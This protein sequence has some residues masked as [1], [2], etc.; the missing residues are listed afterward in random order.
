[1]YLNS[2]Q[3]NHI[4][5]RRVFSSIN[6]INWSKI[7][8]NSNLNRKRIKGSSRIHCDLKY[9]VSFTGSFSLICECV[10]VWRGGGLHK[11]VKSRKEEYPKRPLFQSFHQSKSVQY[12]KKRKILHHEYCTFN[13]N[14]GYLIG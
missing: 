14:L 4:C 2:I 11:Y 12:L 6:I 3:G 8:P 1:M 13:G 5:K 7:C 9:I 10:C